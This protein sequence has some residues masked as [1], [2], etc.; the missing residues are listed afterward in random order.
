MSFNKKW[1]NKDIP[2]QNG[3]ITIVTGAN[4]GLGFEA[5]KALADKNATVIMACRNQQKG[6]EAAKAISYENSDAK[7]DVMKL[8]LSNLKS[9]KEFSDNFTQKYDRLDLLINNAG[10]MMVPYSKTEDGFELQFGVNHLGHF[11]LT[12]FLMPVILKTPGA[13]IV[14]VSSMAHKYG[15]INFDDLNFESKYDKMA[16]YGQ[17]KI[18]NLY[19]THEL[20]R[21]LEL[22]GSATISVAAHPGYTATNLQQHSKF[23]NFLNPFIA[24]KPHMGALPT[25][26]VAVDLEVKGGEYYGPGGFQEM[27]GYPVKVESNELS[28]NKSIAERLWKVSEELT[29]VEFNFEK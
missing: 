9:V 25:L 24:Q 17:S 10:V 4:I 14:N 7:L 23:F 29:G 15:K 21:R 16:S 27:R 3:R 19:F 22:A 8:D 2:D 1:T 11:A 20:Q 6:D 28:H 5:A 13:R 12:G 26:R 18:A